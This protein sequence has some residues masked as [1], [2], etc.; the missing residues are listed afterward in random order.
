M[1]FQKPFLRNERG[2]SFVELAICM[3]LLVLLSS[4][5]F[6]IGLGL[7]EDRIIS[8]AARQG[9]RAAERFSIIGSGKNS[10]GAGQQSTDPTICQP[11]SNVKPSEHNFFHKTCD[12]VALDRG[13]DDAV[14]AQ[15]VDAN[16]RNEFF[17]AHAAR[18]ACAIIGTSTISPADIEITTTMFQSEHPDS[19]STRSFP[20]VAVRVERK[21]QHGL[22]IAGLFNHYI[23]SFAAESRFHL[24]GI[25]TT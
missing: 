17:H 12:T 22:S 25:C 13:L 6:E 2:V 24:R 20:I 3:P 16:T 18:A 11:Q 7:Q 19:T 9:A 14:E 1:R 5:I 15:R 21:K 10:V 23:H 4:G 8:E